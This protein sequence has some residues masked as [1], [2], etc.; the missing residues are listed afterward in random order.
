MFLDEHLI[1][2]KRSQQ[3]AGNGAAFDGSLDTLQQ[4]WVVVTCSIS[5]VV[6]LTYIHQQQQLPPFY[7]HYT[8]HPVLACTSNQELEDFV[9]TCAVHFITYFLYL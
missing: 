3:L 8:G 2:W 7:N 1:A 5:Y 9:I 4:W 6:M